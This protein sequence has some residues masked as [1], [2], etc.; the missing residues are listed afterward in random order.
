[1]DIYIEINNENILLSNEIKQK[2]KLINTI[3]EINNGNNILNFPYI[4][5]NKKVIDLT[6]MTEDII[7]EL[8]LNEIIEWYNFMNYLGID[9][10]SK[11]ELDVWLKIIHNE[12]IEYI[13]PEATK[14]YIKLCRIYINHMITLHE[15]VLINEYMIVGQLMYD[16]YDFEWNVFIG[17]MIAC[18]GNL[19]C[20]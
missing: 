1:M 12:N 20:L 18:T 10:I 5:E 19:K 8:T 6:I 17:N 11:G 2:S 14:I 15:A 4:I 13:I 7:K 3:I 16:N 9:T